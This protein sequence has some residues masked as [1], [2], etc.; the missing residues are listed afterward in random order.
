[1]NTHTTTSDRSLVT[2]RTLVA[3]LGLLALGGLPRLAEAAVNV[4]IGIDLP[5][6]PRLVPVPAAPAVVYA[7]AVHANYFQYSGRYYVFTN[8]V[9][10]VG[11]R[12]NGPWV[13]AQHVPAPV[14]GVPV[15]YYRTP[16]PAWRHWSRDAAPH[17]KEHKHW[18]NGHGHGHGKGH[19]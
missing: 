13:V 19:G 6:P 17:W 18:K 10:Y 15:R 4:N 3:G 7:P 1:M 11:P 9:W 14:L 2:R 16:P 12:Y 8:D 5:G